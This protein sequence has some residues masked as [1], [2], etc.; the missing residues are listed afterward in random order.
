VTLHPDA[1]WALLSHRWPLNMHELEQALAA[2]LLLAKGGPLEVAH[3][4]EA[5]RAARPAPLAAAV[6]AVTP[7]PAPPLA[8]QRPRSAAD[9]PAAEDVHALAEMLNAP[10]TLNTARRILE[11]HLGPLP[12]EEPPAPAPRRKLLWGGLGLVLL[13]LLALAAWRLGAPTP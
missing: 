11:Q 13:A 6:P 5:I 10:V 1:A 2:A 9:P 12:P 4:P 8:G 7:T 3:L